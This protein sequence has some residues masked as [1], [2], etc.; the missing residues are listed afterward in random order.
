MR[1]LALL[2]PALLLAACTV[3]PDYA[4]PPIGTPPEF[5]GAMAPP[6]EP[7]LAGQAW[8]QIF[9]DETLHA[10]IREGLARNYDVRIAATRIR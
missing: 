9:P 10:L 8:W 1:R 2:A 5:R 6:T 4:R 3:G 7:S